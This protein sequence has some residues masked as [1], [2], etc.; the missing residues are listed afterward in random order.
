MADGE[1]DSNIPG[2]VNGLHIDDPMEVEE[3][4]RTEHVAFAAP[5][6]RYKDCRPVCLATSGILSTRA[7]EARPDS[8][9]PLRRSLLLYGL[10]PDTPKEEVSYK[11]MFALAVDVGAIEDID[12]FQCRL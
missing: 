3:Q 8:D 2:G 5:P 11:Q 1:Q 4:L 7:L 12:R 6:V 9:S 10:D